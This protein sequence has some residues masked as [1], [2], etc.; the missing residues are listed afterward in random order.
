MDL[1]LDQQKLCQ[2]VHNCVT[3]L[4]FCYE[5]LKT[6][7]CFSTLQGLLSKCTQYPAVLLLQLVDLEILAPGINKE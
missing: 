7:L 4:D 2:P 3:T 5:S 1:V 6:I